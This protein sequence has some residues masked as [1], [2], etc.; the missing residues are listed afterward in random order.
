M[1]Y[2]SRI[3]TSHLRKLTI[4]RI[5]QPLLYLGLIVYL[6]VE[7]IFTVDMLYNYTIPGAQHK[8]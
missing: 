8:A 5:R 4:I 1:K 2:A 6:V 7:Y 3:R